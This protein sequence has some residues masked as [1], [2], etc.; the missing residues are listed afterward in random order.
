[1]EEGTQRGQEN[2]EDMLVLPEKEEIGSMGSKGKQG[3]NRGKKY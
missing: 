1:M 3:T 2:W